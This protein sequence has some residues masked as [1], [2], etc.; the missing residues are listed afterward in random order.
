MPSG[1]CM[2]MVHFATYFI[3]NVLDCF[4]IDAETRGS[5]LKGGGSRPLDP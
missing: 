3:V 1:K 2:K 5:Y 4:G